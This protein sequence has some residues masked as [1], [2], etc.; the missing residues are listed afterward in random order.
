MLK[1]IDHYEP[2]RPPYSRVCTVT[3]TEHIVCAVQPYLVPDRA[4][5]DD[6]K[7]GAVGG[8]RSV[9]D[10]VGVVLKEDFQRGQDHWEIGREATRHDGIGSRLLCSQETTSHWDFTDD[11]LGGK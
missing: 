8:A 3:G 2:H 10:A 11:M 7:C 9:V 6:S 4:V 1:Y 5:Y